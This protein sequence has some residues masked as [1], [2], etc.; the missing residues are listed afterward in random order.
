MLS[1]VSTGINW[2][3]FFFWFSTNLVTKNI[4]YILTLLY[5]FSRGP[6]FLWDTC[7]PCCQ[8][9]FCNLCRVRGSELGLVPFRDRTWFHVPFRFLLW[10]ASWAPVQGYAA[11][12]RFWKHLLTESD[13][14]KSDGNLRMG[15]ES[16]LSLFR[17]TQTQTGHQSDSEWQRKQLEPRPRLYTAHVLPPYLLFM[18]RTAGVMMWRGLLQ[19][20]DCQFLLFIIQ[21]LKFCL[22]KSPP[23]PLPSSGRIV[24]TLL[25][26]VDV[27]YPPSAHNDAVRATGTTCTFSC[28]HF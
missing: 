27:F 15:L 19:L 6:L 14:W 3:F 2:Y 28:T 9:V 16:D 11:D 8:T 26:F 24:P 4:S 7:S 1:F 5:L 10:G 18:P 22:I 17:L 25:W 20:N 13:L 23:S 21:Y 12:I